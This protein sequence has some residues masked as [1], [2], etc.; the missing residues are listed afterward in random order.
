MEVS[1]RRVEGRCLIR[2]IGFLLPSGRILMPEI[3]AGSRM[4]VAFP[5]KSRLD[6]HDMYTRLIVLKM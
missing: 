2:R 6:G 5:E 3:N 4:V 1:G